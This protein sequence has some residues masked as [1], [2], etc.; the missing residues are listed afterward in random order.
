MQHL[1][2]LPEVVDRG[3]EDSR[4]RK[5]EGKLRRRLSREPEDEAPDDGRARTARPRNHRKALTEAHGERVLPR[6]V[7]HR[8]DARLNAEA[9]LAVF[10]PQNEEPA[11]DE[12]H[13]DRH[14]VEEIGLDETGHENADHGRGQKGHDRVDGETLFLGF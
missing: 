12:R 11:H 14:G 5:E 13:G 8:R 7:V 9:L 6:H 4:N 2:G 1:A 10:D 3:S